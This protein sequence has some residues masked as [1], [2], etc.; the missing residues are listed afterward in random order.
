MVIR[1]RADGEGATIER[2]GMQREEVACPGCGSLQAILIENIA[3]ASA[4][5]TCTECKR[6]FRANRREYEIV[7]R[8]VEPS[9][10]EMLFINSVRDALPPQPWPKGIHTE[11]AVR[12]GSTGSK[13]Q[14]AIGKLIAAGVFRPQIDGVVYEPVPQSL[15]NE[16]RTEASGGS[17]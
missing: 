3:Y 4:N 16:V 14:K 15:P 13:I 1:P 6:E 8:S 10:S 9:D 12:L 11:I 17:G 5:T 2:R 7:C